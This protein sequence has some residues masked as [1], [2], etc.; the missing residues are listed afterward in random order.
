MNETKWTPGPWWTD[1]VY[2]EE[3]CGCSIGR[4]AFAIEILPDHAEVAKANAHL[5]AAAPDMADALKPFEKALAWFEARMTEDEMKF[6][7]EKTF[8]IGCE[9]TVA[10]LRNAVAALAKAR[11]EQTK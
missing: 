2:D 8:M 9:I 11:G 5:I 7:N 3:D 1:A 10:D 6:M 4:V